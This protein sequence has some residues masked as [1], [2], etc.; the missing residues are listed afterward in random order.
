MEVESSGHFEGVKYING[1]FGLGMRDGVGF[2]LFG[3]GSV[4]RSC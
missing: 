2:G 3:K 1:V 4:I